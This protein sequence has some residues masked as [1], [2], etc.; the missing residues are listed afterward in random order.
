[1]ADHNGASYS[2]IWCSIMFVFTIESGHKYFWTWLL[3][4]ASG[5]NSGI[6]KLFRLVTCFSFSTSSSTCSSSTPSKDKWNKQQNTH[7][8]IHTHAFSSSWKTC[9]QSVLWYGMIYKLDLGINDHKVGLCLCPS[10]R[11]HCHHHE[12][13]CSCLRLHSPQILLAC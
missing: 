8:H 11:H 4:R 3:G 7:T 12:G 6:P 1:M 5:S 13:P 2:E 9:A 10:H